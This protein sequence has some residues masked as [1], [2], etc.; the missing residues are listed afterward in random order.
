MFIKEI[1]KNFNNFVVEKTDPLK[2]AM[3]RITNNRK[4]AI[5]V[6]DKKKRVCGVLSDGDIRRA[7]LRGVLLITPVE[8]IM[9]VNY[10]FYQDGMDRT[11]EEIF[12]QNKQVTILPVITRDHKLLGILT[13]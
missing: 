3:E 6:I 12:R 1:S 7:L 13:V 4:G 2:T 10:I 11:P 9:N 5:V 8:K